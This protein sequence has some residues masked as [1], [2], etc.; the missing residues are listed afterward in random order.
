MN[1]CSTVKSS[2]QQVYNRQAPKL[3]LVL[4]FKVQIRIQYIQHINLQYSLYHQ[5]NCSSLLDR[6]LELNLDSDR[7]DPEGKSDR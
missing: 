3:P 2:E 5:L 6:W 4:L 7:S 1:S